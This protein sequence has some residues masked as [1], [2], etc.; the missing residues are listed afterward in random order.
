MATEAGILLDGD[1]TTKENSTGLDVM[2]PTGESRL[3]RIL[4]SG[5]FALAVMAA[6]Y[7]G[8]P[9]FL[10]LAMAFLLSFVLRPVVRKI[11]ELGV[12]APATAFLMVCSLA[13]TLTFAAIHLKEP[14]MQWLEE[15]PESLQ[16][17]HTRIRLL[18]QPIAEVREATEKLSELG[19]DV[20]AKT[21]EIV[22]RNGGMDDQFIA[23]A[24]DAAVAAFTTMIFLFF[25]LGWGDRLFRNVVNALPNFH[26][27]RRAVVV[28]R[29]VESAIAIYLFT[30]TLINIGLGAVVALVLYTLGMPNPLL[31]GV[32]AAVLNYIPYIGTVITAS[33]LGFVALITFPSLG[34]AM[35]IPAV[36]LAITTIEGY[37]ITPAALGNQLTLN[38]LLIFLS[39]VL[40]YA[41]WGVIGALLTV[42]ILV[43][44]K[45]ILER[46]ETG[47]HLARILD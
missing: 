11:C 1:D 45:V 43:V 29:D 44:I 30:I 22:V 33:V 15:T 38:P 32:M 2:V 5:L 14:A 13:G 27:Q 19:N 10:P 41:M 8:R 4:V 34:E 21:T 46:L 42:P 20:K 6:L 7:F 35:L 3:L 36:F 47:S 31:W 12:P 26:E 40:W 17:L 37:L 28:A 25:I 18:K 39:L 9:V 24:S 23:A 16:Q